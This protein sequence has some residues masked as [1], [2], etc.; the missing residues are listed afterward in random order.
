METEL[1]ETADAGAVKLAAAGKRLA[2]WFQREDDILRRA[3]RIGE[4]HLAANPDDT[5]TAASVATLREQ[6]REL[7]RGWENSS[8]RRA[9]GERGGQSAAGGAETRSI[10]TRGFS[11]P[12]ER[13]AAGTSTV[14]TAVRLTGHAAV[15]NKWTTIGDF[16]RERVAPGAFTEVIKTADTRCLFNHD[17]SHIYGRTTANTLELSEDRIGLAFVCHLLPF[18][19]ASYGLAR[20]IDRRDISGC[21]FSFRVG[22][23]TWRLAPNK[24]DLDECT[25]L[26]IS[27]LWDVGPVTYPAYPQ[28]DVA[29]VFETV[30]GRSVSDAEPGGESY[31]EYSERFEREEYESWLDA[32]RTERLSAL[33]KRLRRSMDPDHRRINAVLARLGR[34]VT[35]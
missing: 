32:Q 20:R 31:E 35:P 16:F 30:P 14:T 25:I 17:D 3:I 29:A 15:F 13:R 4:E 18:D 8:L 26:E 28:T 23:E 2:N 1:R 24:G 33:E 9:V 34:P 11:L 21:S 6:R 22:K 12:A 5:E 19:S 10:A 7:H 27:Q